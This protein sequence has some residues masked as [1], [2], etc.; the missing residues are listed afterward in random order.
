MVTIFVILS[1]LSF[2]GVPPLVGFLSKFLI[3]IH[4]FFKSNVV[5]FMFFLFINL[6]VIYFYLQNLRFMISKQI[7]NIFIYKNYSAYLNKSSLF[8]TNFTNFL[9]V[10]GIFYFEELLLY[11]NL[12]SSTILLY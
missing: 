9:N 2:S 6:F 7:S 4:I 5:I 8:F 1:F 3:F 12:L 10:S 11:F